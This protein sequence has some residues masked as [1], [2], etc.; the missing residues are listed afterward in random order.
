MVLVTRLSVWKFKVF[1]F[2]QKFFKLK[3]AKAEANKEAVA[4]KGSKLG[5]EKVVSTK[6]RT[7]LKIAGLYDKEPSQLKLLKRKDVPEMHKL[8]KKSYPHSR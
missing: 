2:L 1:A 7:H 3:T 8:R 4:D 5:K 6:G